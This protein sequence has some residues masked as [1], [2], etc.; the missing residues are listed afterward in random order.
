MY[1]LQFTTGELFPKVFRGG[2]LVSIW[3]IFQAGI[4]D[5]AEYTRQQLNI[6]FGI[7]E[8]R[9]GDLLD[10]TERFFKATLRLSAFPDKRVRSR[11]ELLKGFRNALAHHDGSVDEMP[12]Q[13][14]HEGAS[15]FSTFSDLHHVYAV[16]TA[17]YLQESIDLTELVITELGRAVYDKLHGQ[18]EG[19]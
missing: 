8:L 5:I 17:A 1:I 2:F 12:R 10:Q 16:P 14:K 11:V 19:P 4:K 9:G 6:P 3:S 18:P 13:L 7:Q 15:A